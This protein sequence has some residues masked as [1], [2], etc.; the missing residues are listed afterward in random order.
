MTTGGPSEERTAAGAPPKNDITRAARATV[1][2]VLVVATALAL[3]RLRDLIVLLLL[4]LT[5]AAA[6]RPGVEWLHRRR[7]PQSVSILLFFVLI[8]GLFGV[9]IWLAV[10]PAIREVGQALSHPGPSGS[11]LRHST[12]IRH[13]V[14]VWLDKNLHHLPSGS[15]IHPV[16]TYGQKA[17][18]AAVAFLFL[19]A[20]TWYWISERDS[21]IDLLSRPAS[22]DRREKVRATLLEID[23]KL[24]VYTRVKFAMTFAVAIVL[25]TGFYLVG[26]NYW[27]L[28]GGAVALFEIIPVVGPLAGTILVAGV[29]LS[30]SVHTAVLG[31]I[32][33]VGV[34]EFQS[35]VVNPHLAGR[36]VGLSP[37]VTL[38]AV[39]VVGVLFGAFAVVLAIPA[40][41]AAATL[42]DV[43]VL[44][45]PLPT[46]ES[47][48]RRR[49]PSP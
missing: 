18:K 35:Y 21:M 42:I 29:G 49:A 1:G 33:V 30:Q 19:L 17:T 46:T 23:R 9:F 48:R 10:P 47:R 11:S 16:A 36:T 15:I 25:A 7:V 20:A 12:G 40:A 39:S 34:R 4:S 31:V 24:G 14:L 41:A 22:P 32:V 45:Q 13:D 26:L 44:D 38:V 6:M 27:L 37:L 2:V 3:W 5:F 28:L 43:L 8:L